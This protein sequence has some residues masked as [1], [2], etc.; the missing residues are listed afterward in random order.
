[1]RIL[2]L[3]QLVDIVRIA[4]KVVAGQEDILKAS[5]LQYFP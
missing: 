5:K 4:H 2:N 3:T 1:M